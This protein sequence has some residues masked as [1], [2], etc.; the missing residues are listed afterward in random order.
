MANLYTTNNFEIV[1]S[2]NKRSIGGFFEKVAE[3]WLCRS[4]FKVISRNWHAGHSELDLIVEKEN[5]RVFVEVKYL[6]GRTNFFPESKINSKKWKNILK[7][8]QEFNLQYPNNKRI[9]FD[10]IA[11][12]KNKW[13]MQLVH[14]KDAYSGLRWSCN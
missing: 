2:D 7:S 1:M 13:S 6:S 5:Y 4:N 3:E 9:R 11:I 14:Y 8:A 12:I 10:V